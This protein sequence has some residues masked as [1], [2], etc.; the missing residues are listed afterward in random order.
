METILATA[1]GTKVSLL[2]GEGHALSEAADGAFKIIG[3]TLLWSV[4]LLCK[5]N[6]S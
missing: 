6:N 2:K 3:P 5:D 4:C 1:F